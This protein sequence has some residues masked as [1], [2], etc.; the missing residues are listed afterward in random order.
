[1]ERAFIPTA[2]TAEEMVLIYKAVD[3]MVTALMANR[4]RIKDLEMLE[5]V[6]KYRKL[7]S[8]LGQIL[9]LAEELEQQLNETETSETVSYSERTEE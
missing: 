2:M 3:T 1:M 6:Y 4:H 5:D 9:D 8:K 7:K